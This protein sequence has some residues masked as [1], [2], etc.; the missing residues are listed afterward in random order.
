MYYAGFSAVNGVLVRAFFGAEGVW[1]WGAITTSATVISTV[2]VSA[3]TVISVPTTSGAAIAPTAVSATAASSPSDHIRHLTARGILYLWR[4]IHHVLY[5][6]RGRIEVIAHLLVAQDVGFQ[7]NKVVA[8]QPIKK[9][10]NLL[11][12]EHTIVCSQRVLFIKC[13]VELHVLG[14]VVFNL[15]ILDI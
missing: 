6:C 8:F 14:D 9:A 12:F 7:A 1:V 13:G 11:F 5:V 10:V 15:P 4:P 2:P 3:A